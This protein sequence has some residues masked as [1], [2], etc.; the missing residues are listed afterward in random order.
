MK[1]IQIVSLF[2]FF[3]L[4]GV[5]YAEGENG[6]PPPAAA[7]NAGANVSA[8]ANPLEGTSEAIAK[9]LE[10]YRKQAQQVILQLQKYIETSPA[11]PK[12]DKMRR[13]A[14]RLAGDDKFLQS[15]EDL[16]HSPNRNK[17]FTYQVGFF[18][19]MLII[20]AWW[21]SSARHWFQKF[22]IGL[23]CTL[24]TWIGVSYL[25]PLLVLGAPFGVFTGTLWKA[26]VAGS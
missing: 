11:D 25:I 8:N 23:V 24:I 17:M 12:L 10:E 1:I 15:A 18:L 26:F 9:N 13:V 2:L 14:M 7:P 22:F 5:V 6:S 4:I 19:L 21:Q 16:W 3:A 20:K